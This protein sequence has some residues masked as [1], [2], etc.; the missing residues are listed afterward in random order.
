MMN[1]L[2]QNYNNIL[3]KINILAR[4]QNRTVQLIAVSKTFPSTN[5]RELFQIGQTNFAE[6]YAQEF[7]VKVQELSDLPIK[8]HFIGN[9]QSNKTKLISQHADW[10]HSITTAKHA[11]RLNNDRPAKKESL[12]VLIEVNIS[13]DN[14]KHGL[15]TIEEILSL[16]EIIS[17]Q[18]RLT[19]RGL[20]GVAS[21]INDAQLIN[22]QFHALHNLFLQLQHEYAVDTLSMG[23]SSDYEFAILNGATQV[24]I[25]SLIFGERDYK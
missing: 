20:M 23:M 2:I 21:H 6:N 18:G 24:R 11:I 14:N 1:A 15:S 19:L 22:E 16:A 4:E 9:I 8:W 12:N 5:I 13:H 7:A 25:G 17:Q 10:V 3:N